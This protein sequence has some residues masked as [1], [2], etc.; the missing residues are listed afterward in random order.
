LDG[1][2]L[3][4]QDGVVW[5]VDQRREIWSP[6]PEF[7][8]VIDAH[9]ET[10]SLVVIEHWEKLLGNWASSLR[11]ETL[12]VRDLKTGA[13]RY[14]VWGSHPRPAH[15]SADRQL[16]IAGDNCVYQLPPRVNIVLLTLGQAVLALPIVLPWALIC[17]RRRRTKSG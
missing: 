16:G 14:R 1:R 9:A 5:D 8:V 2:V 12:A 13:F 3:V 7:E 15:W 4:T 10:H 17:W 11:I 6:I